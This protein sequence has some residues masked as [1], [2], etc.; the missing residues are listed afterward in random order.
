MFDIIKAST[1]YIC[2]KIPF[3]DFR[4]FNV[5]K[6]T[7]SVELDNISLLRKI[8][9]DYVDKY[10]YYFYCALNDYSQYIEYLPEGAT[11]L[12]LRS[13]DYQNMLKYLIFCYPQKKLIW[14]FFIINLN[15]TDSKF[16]IIL[17]FL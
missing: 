15:L 3:F 5:G 8:Y 1:Y 9:C 12:D 6:N 16:L 13:N 11:I 14:I 2:F 4:Y 10:D 7:I 17:S